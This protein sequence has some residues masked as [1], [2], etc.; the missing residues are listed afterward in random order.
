MKK[1]R[2]LIIGLTPPVE[3]GSQQHILHLVKNLNKEKFNV[4]L[5]TQ[6]GTSCKEYTNCLEIDLGDKKGYS[7]SLAFYNGVKS[8]IPL[9]KDFDIVHIHESY[10]FLLVAKIKAKVSAKVILTVHGMKG[11][12]Y[13]NS[14]LL[15]KLFKERMTDAD[16]L[17]AVSQTD[18]KLLIENFPKEKISYIPNGVDLEPYTKNVA[19]IKNKITFIGRMHEQK[20]VAV[21]LKAFEEVSNSF[22]ELR[23]ELIGEVNGYARS[24]QSEFRNP[25][26]SWKGYL[27][28]R[29]EIVQSLKSSYCIVIPSLW[30]GLPLTLFE[31]L[32]SER[33]VIVSDIETFKSVIKNDEAVMFKSEDAK[34]LAAKIVAVIQNRFTSDNYGKRG[35][36]LAEKYNWVNIVNTFEGV[37][38][39]YGQ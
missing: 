23:L 28:N 20:G 9:M 27:S 38:H 35:R 8:K 7:Q 14:K 19:Q 32:A 13:Y 26:I 34:D 11:F 29:D 5:L 17:I 12:K 1:Q 18:K 39:K 24:L 3:G 6:K 37:Y 22:P 10:L 25:N 31:A 33:P 16:A 36:T 30:E 2:I 4:T 15:W 21:L